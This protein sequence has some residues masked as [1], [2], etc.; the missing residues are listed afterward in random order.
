MWLPEGIL[1]LR[2]ESP[3][4]GPPTRRF[5]KKPDS[6][7]ER[8]F[9]HPLDKY[10]GGLC[11]LTLLYCVLWKQGEQPSWGLSLGNMELK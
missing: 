11:S 5:T 10:T 4:H 2:R 7:M 3:P 8:T 1:F 6:A 9:L